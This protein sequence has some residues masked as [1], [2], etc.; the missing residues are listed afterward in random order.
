VDRGEFRWL[1]GG[2]LAFSAL[3]LILG[4]LVQGID[5]SA[6]AGGLVA[7]MLLGALLAVPWTSQSPPVLRANVAGLLLLLVALT[8]LITRLPP[9]TYLLGDELRARAAIEAFLVQDQS[10]SKTL[11]RL[12]KQSAKDPRS[13][14]ALA[15]RIETDV[16]AVYA[17][18]FEQLQQT[19]PGS[20]VP[21]AATLQ[22]LRDYADMRAE[23]THELAQSIRIGD[24]KRAREALQ[25]TRQAPAR[26]A[27]AAVA[28]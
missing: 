21:S 7:G 25:K 5:N 12:L 1:F 2:A 19:A 8:L 15:G 13:F 24:V 18:S 4:Q 9:P 27:S 20:A 26:A 28:K 16:S 14:D 22:S 6:H 23:A 3:M 11:D 10:A 17:K